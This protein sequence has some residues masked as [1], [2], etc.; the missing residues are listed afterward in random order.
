LPTHPELL[1]YL[2]LEFVES[3]WDVKALLRQIVMSATYRQASHAGPEL[4]SLDPEN[5]LLAR[6]PRFRLPAELLRDHALASAG[7]LSVK[8][9]GPSVKPY[10][11][12]G[13]WEEVSFNED[14]SYLQNTDDGLWRRSLYTYCKRQAPPPALLTFDSGTREKC[15]VRRS[16]TN[17]PLQSLVTMNDPTWI[18]A[19]RVLAERCIKG[20]N[21]DRERLTMMFRRIVTREPNEAEFLLLLPFIERERARFQDRPE[22]ARNLLGV[23]A[24]KRDVTIDP[25]EAAAW[26]V[27]AHTVLNLDEV[28]TRR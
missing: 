21:S 22:Q 28:V 2:A 20:G 6:G 25:I 1:D 15:V 17:T 18:E 12:D 26:T 16:R 24:A 4:L 10:Q 5:R 14:D 27:V 19:A 8:I 9:G 23:G 3:G 13:L 11:P 7:L